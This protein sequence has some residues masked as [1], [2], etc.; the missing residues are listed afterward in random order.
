ML[1]NV[2]KRS[3]A[4]LIRAAL[5]LQC[6]NAFFRGQVDVPTPVSSS[7]ET[8]EVV[9]GERARAIAVNDP[10]NLRNGVGQLACDVR[11]QVC[12]L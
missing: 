7:V 10:A 1:G 3:V 2:M 11:R 6:F 4:I 8:A 12:L 5:A 9:K